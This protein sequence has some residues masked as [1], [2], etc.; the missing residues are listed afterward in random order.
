MNDFEFICLDLDGTLLD[1]D[2]KIGQDSRR[3]IKELR[4]RSKKILLASGRHLRETKEF[5]EELDLGSDDIVISCD[6]QY[7]NHCDGKLIWSAPFLDAKDLN[8][9]IRQ[10]TPNTMSIITDKADYK[11]VSSYRDFIIGSL[12]KILRP[13]S[14]TVVRRRMASVCKGLNVEKVILKDLP[15]SSLNDLSQHYSVHCISTDYRRV[16]ILRNG[17]NKYNA[18]KVLTQKGIIGNLDSLVYFGNDMNDV[19]CFNYL[20]Y[21]VAM[22]DSPE[23]LKSKAFMV[24]EDCNHDGVA[25]ALLKLFY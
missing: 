4:A 3:I 24:T 20:R 18:L 5:C 22:D 10:A 21:C 23:E 15:N 16:E 7:I 12:K 14:V 9:I 25:L 2:K 17:V 19:E 8:E 1:S 6:G 13:H 11:Y